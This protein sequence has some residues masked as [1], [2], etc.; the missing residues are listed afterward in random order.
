MH[1]L[2]SLCFGIVLLATTAVAFDVHIRCATAE[3]VS[4]ARRILVQQAMNPLAVTQLCLLVANVVHDGGDLPE[5]MAG[6]GQIR[7]VDENHSELASLYVLPEYRRRGIATRLIA[8]LLERHDNQNNEAAATTPTTTT[9]PTAVCL[10]TLRPTVPLYEAHG[11]GV[12][13]HK[14][15]LPA[16]MQW[17]Y[18][19]GSL[20][21]AAL[22]N[23]LVGMQRPSPSRTALG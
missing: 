7:P 22:G 15:D 8:A 23:D 9:T 3:Q 10:L 13:L 18:V 20:L 17:E 14:R 19:A 2:T 21:S 5:E 16:A 11:F 4:T 6:F 1:V 12:V